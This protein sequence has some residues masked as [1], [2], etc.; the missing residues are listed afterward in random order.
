[1]NEQIKGVT[2]IIHERKFARG[3]HR[4]EPKSETVVRNVVGIELV[5]EHAT[6][7]YKFDDEMVLGWAMDRK[8]TLYRGSVSYR[9][10]RV[11]VEAWTFDNHPPLFWGGSLEIGWV[12]EQVSMWNWSR[13][14]DWPD[15][16]K[17]YD[18]WHQPAFQAIKKYLGEKEFDRNWD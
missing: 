4:W 8:W 9:K 11:K 1:M 18:Y 17:V 16:G 10:Q 2:R 3:R 13:V 14:H 6:L 12:P 5:E 15:G 7:P